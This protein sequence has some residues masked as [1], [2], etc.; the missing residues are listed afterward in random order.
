MWSLGF[1]MWARAKLALRLDPVVEITAVSGSALQVP[2]V[3]G[4]RDLVVR[5][6]RG[7]P[8]RPGG[9]ADALRGSGRAPPRP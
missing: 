6:A 2:L 7:G 3:R 1:G 8:A 5:R 9:T 4:L